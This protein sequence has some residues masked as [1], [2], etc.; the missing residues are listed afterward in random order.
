MKAQRAH[1][2]SRRPTTSSWCPKRNQ[3]GDGQRNRGKT[4][5]LSHKA[6][7]NQRKGFSISL[8]TRMSAARK[9]WELRREKR[10]KSTRRTGTIGVLRRIPRQILPE[11][12]ASHIVTISARNRWR[13]TCS[14]DHLGMRSVGL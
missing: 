5:S 9:K 1:V 4:S 11:A 3:S 6:T 14:K 7:K 2:Q 8:L 10:A 13:V 12:V